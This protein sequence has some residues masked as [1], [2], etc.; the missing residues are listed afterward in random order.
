MAV[1]SPLAAAAVVALWGAVEVAV[2]S[3]VAAAGGA[4]WWWAVERAGASLLAAAVVALWWAVE[5]AVASPLA[6]AV[7]GSA[8]ASADWFVRRRSWLRR[9]PLVM[10]GL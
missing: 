10:A 5:M 8:V 2:A 6:A 1:A 4:A 3:P 7:V 9:R